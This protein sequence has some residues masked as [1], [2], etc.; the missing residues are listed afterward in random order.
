MIYRRIS[1]Y[2]IIGYFGPAA[3]EHN[4]AAITHSHTDDLL[5]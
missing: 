3:Y 4:I 1:S 5:Q 2:R